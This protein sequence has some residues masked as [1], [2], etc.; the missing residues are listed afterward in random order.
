[1]ILQKISYNCI[2]QNKLFFEVRS[3]Q[4]KNMT[5]SL[6]L[7]LVCFLGLA[8]LANCEPKSIEMLM[9]NVS[10]KEVRLLVKYH[11]FKVE[12]APTF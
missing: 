7:M 11:Y 1:M 10:P 8:V 5:S 2:K 3:K 9:P 4:N 12:D 6:C